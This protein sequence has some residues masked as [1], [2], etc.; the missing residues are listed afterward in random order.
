MAGGCS[1][2][3]GCPNDKAWAVVKDDKVYRITFSQSLA[4]HAIKC[5]ED[6]NFTLAR[7][8]LK[9][10]NEIGPGQNSPTG[11]YAL[12]DRRKGKTLR[13]AMNKELAN[14]VCDFKSRYLAEAFIEKVVPMTN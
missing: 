3:K 6:P 12:I 2:T 14:L 5:T 1:T 8:T 9:I 13:V 4:E 10:G 7:I 11:L